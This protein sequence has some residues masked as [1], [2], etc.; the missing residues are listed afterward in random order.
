MNETSSSVVAF[1]TVG[2]A[3]LRRYIEPALEKFAEARPDATSAELA[4]AR[5][6]IYQSG[7][8]MAV[9]SRLVGRLDAVELKGGCTGLYVGDFHFIPSTG[10]T[11]A[12]RQA[13]AQII[14]TDVPE[15]ERL[16]LLA[17]LPAPRK[18]PGQYL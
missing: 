8:C 7:C 9:L 1:D 18:P 2:D 16:R 4:A 11:L 6:V 3:I 5:A 17:Q 15:E 12:A 10:D 13:V 14:L